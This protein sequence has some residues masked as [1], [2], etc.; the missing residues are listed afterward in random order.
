MEK[1]SN[2]A[3]NLFV[4]DLSMEMNDVAKLAFC[5]DKAFVI[6]HHETT[7]NVKFPNGIKNIINTKLSGTGLVYK[8]MTEKLKYKFTPE[9]KLLAKIINDYDLF[10][11]KYS[12]SLVANELFWNMHFWDFF[13]R[14]KD[15]WN[16][17]QKEVQVGEASLQAKIDNIKTLK[18]F[19]PICA[20]C[21]KIRDHE[22]FWE[23]VEVYVS[24]HTEAEFSHGICPGCAQE[25]YPD[26]MKK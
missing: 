14:F 19:V 24:D 22:G 17:T 20:K 1:I 7:K 9:L 10:K 15:G 23:S 4:T 11:L 13:D 18:G 16:P 3:D 21:K 8:W 5:F 12:D 26:L 2:F 6:D 25:L